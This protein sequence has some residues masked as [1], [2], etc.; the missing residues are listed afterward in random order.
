[1]KQLKVSNVPT[2][3]LKKTD[4]VLENVEMPWRLVF[5]PVNGQYS[6]NIIFYKSLEEKVNVLFKNL[7][8]LD[9]IKATMTL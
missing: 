7:G 4:F 1:M 6:I 3:N 8:S 2:G 9:K 5:E